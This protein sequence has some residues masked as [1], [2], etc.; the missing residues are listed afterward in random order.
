MAHLKV[1]KYKSNKDRYLAWQDLVVFYYAKGNIKKYVKAKRKELL[2]ISLEY[3]SPGGMEKYIADFEELI[4]E[5]ENIHESINESLEITCFLGGIRDPYFNTIKTVCKAESYVIT[6]CISEM[7]RVG[8]KS[9]SDN[10]QM[11]NS[12]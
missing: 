10:S 7:R 1:Q 11:S 12:G 5:L 6:K 8:L 4:C 9:L 2:S 3:Y